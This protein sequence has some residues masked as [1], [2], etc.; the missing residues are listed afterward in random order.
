MAGMLKPS[1]YWLLIFVP[2]SLLAELLLKQPV[3]VFASACVAIVPLAGLIGEATD[4]LALRSGPRVGGLL[5]ATFGNVTELIIAVLLVAAGEFDVVKASLIG[6]ILGNLVLVLGAAYLA[7]GLRFKEQH[8]DPRAASLHSAALLLAVT[9]LLMPAVFVLTQPDTTVQREVISVTVAAV[10]IILYIASLV[11]TLITHAH[12]FGASREEAAPEWSGRRAVLVLLVTA[13]VVGFESELLVGSLEP[14][15]RT[16]GISKLFV[17]L[18]V[19]A[20][21][22]NAAEHAS[23]VTFALRGRVEVAIEIAFGSSTQIALLVAPLLVFISLAI[24]RPM[25]FV[26][27]TAEVIAVALATLVV[28]VISLDGRSTW[29]A[30]VQLLGVYVI[31][32]VSFFY[33]SGP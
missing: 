12:L 1:I 33:V 17:G 18:F 20:I 4:Q 28:A 5:N 7:G 6:S 16:L 21:I 23:A 30:G 31:L 19:V 15:I 29:L 9:G 13:I 26:F 2:L 25:D 10:L 24:S 11:F 27:S 32:G 3:L 22:G 14:A 8:F